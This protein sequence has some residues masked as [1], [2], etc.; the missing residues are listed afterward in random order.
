MRGAEALKTLDAPLAENTMKLNK[1]PTQ[2]Y[3][4]VHVAGS[5]PKHM[6]IISFV[7]AKKSLAGLPRVVGDERH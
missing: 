5:H 4:L 6:R 1:C 3:L 2:A 7:P